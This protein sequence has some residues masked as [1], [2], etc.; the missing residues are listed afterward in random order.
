MNFVET[1]RAA[2]VTCENGSFPV[3][4][5][6]EDA[7][8]WLICNAVSVEPLVESE[9]CLCAMQAERIVAAISV[10]AEKVGAKRSVIAV[11]SDDGPAA[12][13]LAQ[14]IASSHAPVEL[15][16]AEA[17][18]PSNDVSVLIERITGRIVAERGIPADVGCTVTDPQQA[19]DILSALEGAPVTDRY[20]TVTGA[21]KRQL[22][23]RVPIG[24]RLSACVAEA[25]PVPADVCLLVGG[26][27]RGKLLTTPSAIEAA[28]VSRTTDNLVV[29]PREHPLVER[30]KQSLE[31]I[32]ARA[33]STCG[34]CGICTERCPRYGLGQNM[35]PHRIIQ[36]L[37]RGGEGLST[38]EFSEAFGDTVNCCGCGVC[39]AVCPV[40]L[41]P[42]RINAY[43][44]GG[45]MKRGILVPRERQPELRQMPGI[46]G[47]ETDR[48]TSMLD[49]SEYGGPHRFT[50]G[51]L[52]ADEVR[53][54]FI[55]KPGR[56]MYLIR[57][58]GD[59]VKKGDLLA[60][61]GIDFSIHASIGG[62]IVQINANGAH[63]KAQ[64][65]SV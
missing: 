3:V 42:R 61:D 1:I 29:L 57:S 63:I 18:Y 41:Q 43:F 9:S 24:S 34:Q 31:T 5:E 10:I 55:R 16:K 12:Q 60:S 25:G 8:E 64:G 53:I 14:A 65:V 33:I 17:Y 26:P 35:R 40:G 54:A 51:E 27:M 4:L 52:S 62:T 45:I 36:N 30:G 2:G 11:R 44:R 39:D 28:V 7:V 59:R 20:I 47:I 15:F 50:Y 49:L 48:L 37:K 13:A 32:L 58:A 21:V 6:P 22:L 38:D 23:L 19:L 46:R 56:N